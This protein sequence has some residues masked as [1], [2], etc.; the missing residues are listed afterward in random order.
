MPAFP[1]KLGLCADLA[2]KLRAA[3]LEVEEQVEEMR[4]KEAA[5][6]EHIFTLLAA[7]DLE[8]ATGEWATVSLSHLT[9]PKVTDWDK[10]YAY[11][12]KEGAF[13][14]LERRP[15]KGAYKERLEAKVAVPGVEPMEVTNLNIT[16]VG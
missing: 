11:I 7:Q 1:K 3:R 9:V 8:S 6:K 15:A 12:Q 4:K 13:D 16:K 10:F 5:L 14:L 2:Y